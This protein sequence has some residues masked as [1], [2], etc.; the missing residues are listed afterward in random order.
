[1]GSIRSFVRDKK[2][3]GENNLRFCED[4]NAIPEDKREL[5]NRLGE[6]AKMYEG[7]SESELTDELMRSVEA[8]KQDGSFSKEAVEQFA[9][10]VAPMLNDEQRDKLGDILK[11]LEC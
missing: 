11:M 8:A 7:K 4:N 3:L 6:Q 5:A 2:G 10:R 9:S 1:M